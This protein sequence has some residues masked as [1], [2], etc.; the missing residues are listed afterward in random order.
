MAESR[1]QS[2]L[3]PSQEAT[4]AAPSLVEV[5]V[6]VPL[7]RTFT[8][9]LPGALRGRLEIGSRI[10]VPFARQKLA[11]FVV[12]FPRE[13]PGDITLRPIAGLLDSQPVF[14]VE[15][16]GFLRQAADYYMHPIGEVLRAAAPALPSEAMKALRRS[17]FLGLEE[18]LPGVRLATRTT[19]FARLREGAEPEGRIGKVQGVLLELLK[20]RGEV[21]ID[22]LRR[23]IKGP[24]PAL[25][26]LEARGL[27]ELEQRE[28]AAD[29][30]FATPVS[31]ADAPEPNAD[32]VAAIDALSGALD[33]GGGF[34][35]HGVTGSGK[36]EVYLRVIAEARARGRGALMLV[37]EI[38]LTPQLV[39]RFRARF[40][41]TIA[42]LHSELGAR[43]RD[44]AW[45][46]LRAGRLQLAIGARSAL[47]APVQ[48]LGVIVVDEEHDGSFKQEEGFRYQ[49]RDMALLRAHRASAVCILGSATPS[50]ET[51]AL[52]GAER[53]QRLRL[54]HRATA[55]GLPRVE[56]IDLGLHRGTPSGNRLITGPLQAA[57]GDC[58][59][60]GQQAILFL[61]RRGFAPSV[62]CASC[63]ELLECPDCSVTLTLHRGAGVLRC[64]YCDF[65]TP[66]TG[67]CFKCGAPNVLELGI[68][69]E[70]LEQ[71]L[72]EIFPQARVARLDRD[73][74]SG[75]GV[76][77][78]LGRLRRQEV[79]ILVGT[80]MVT[81]GH[82]IPEVTLVGVV[83]ADQS[84]AFP[85]FRASERTFQLL[86]QVSGRAGRGEL[87]GRVLL[88]TYQPEHPAVASACRHDYERFCELE[89]AARRE[90]SYPPYARLVAIRVDAA[91]EP[92]AAEAADLLAR[93]ARARPEVRAER[94][95]V[96]GPAP[97]P[98]SKIRG[99][100]R[101]RL[102]LKS[103]HRAEL[104]AVAYALV[105]RIDEGLPAARASVDIDPV[106]ML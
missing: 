68:G 64:H 91:T 106:S 2:L 79:D 42:V 86:A 76:E 63:A 36:T 39:G 69:T 103:P 96:L 32:Q 87:P 18:S 30:F 41:D 97:A 58:L 53:L 48:R 98:I 28:V 44:D 70:Q 20:E 78:V 8:Y 40:G 82:D 105:Q 90:L 38:A 1:Q 19:L 95:E 46:A 50:L 37:P 99:R 89:L 23:H 49:A 17:G 71:A 35:L 94:V 31:H 93:L 5:A 25:R 54:P 3:D 27:V 61:N 7:R 60:A 104:R 15:L 102:L 22:E 100:H 51:V 62:R 84:L 66:H 26:T 57:L 6:P 13:A 47:F 29:R 85:D 72:A 80:Q 88:Q 33:G 92:N 65:S 67:S 14:D 16:M 56:V 75:E 77:A 55:H 43:E 4:V 74:A 24:R 52:V 12:G 10:A 73:T 81:K 45:R 11:A 21:S 34:L 101:H 83:L 59:E 9:A